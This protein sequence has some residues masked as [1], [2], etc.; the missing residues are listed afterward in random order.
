M[1]NTDSL[2][3]KVLIAMPGM[4]DPRF[5]RSVVLICAHGDEGAMGLVLNHDIDLRLF[6]THWAFA[7][8]VETPLEKGGVRHSIQFFDKAG[9]A[10]HKIFARP[11]TN[12][13]AWGKLVVGCVVDSLDAPAGGLC[14]VVNEF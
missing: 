8:A 3:G 5:S 1:K 2:T 4:S 7:F 13:D 14:V 12:M 11:V 10:I 6:M 9:I